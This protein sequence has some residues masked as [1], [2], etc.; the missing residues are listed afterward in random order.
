MVPYFVKILKDLDQTIRETLL[1]KGKC[2]L[3][4]CD[5]DPIFKVTGGLIMLQLACPHHISWMKYGF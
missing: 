5:L 2:F 3:V 1:G 4:L